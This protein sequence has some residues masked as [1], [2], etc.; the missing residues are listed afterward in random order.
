MDVS[1]NDRANDSAV[2]SL[3]GRAT[4]IVG[5]H[6]VSAIPSPQGDELI[7]S[8]SAI[9]GLAED[10]V[11]SEVTEMLSLS[12]QPSAASNLSNLSLDELRAAMLVYLETINADMEC[13]E[14]S[15]SSQMPNS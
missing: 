10:S 4:E 8:I 11:K 1:Q 14:D 9:A 5:P 2:D 3:G 13:G 7:R 15:S 12:G 6:G